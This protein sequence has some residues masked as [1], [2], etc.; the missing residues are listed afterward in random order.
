[1]P[2]KAESIWLRLAVSSPTSWRELSPL[3]LLEG[4][5]L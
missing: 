3:L 2:D 1:L 4:R 5:C